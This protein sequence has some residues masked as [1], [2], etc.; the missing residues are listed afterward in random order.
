MTVVVTGGAGRIGSAIVQSLCQQGQS[1]LLQY[2]QS[3]DQ[4][5][6]LQE[7]WPHLVSLYA[8]D[9]TKDGEL[10]TFVEFARQGF[11]IGGLINNAGRFTKSDSSS[12]ERLKMREHWELN[13]VA[14]VYLVQC[15][16]ESLKKNKGSVVN[17]VDNV[18]HT[19]PWPNY[20]GYATSKAALVAATRALAVQFAPD[21]RVNAVGPGLILDGELDS[22]EHQTLC[23]KIPMK[24]WGT[25]MEVAQTVLFLLQGPAYITGQVLCVDGGWGLSP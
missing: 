22:P 13:T 2:H 7:Q 17:I 23:K 16:L 10:Q 18:S 25:P 12:V 15:L 6:A 21:V 24:R 11:T 5:V 19:R 8:C 20:V 3:K 14:P 4:A 9:L 1:V